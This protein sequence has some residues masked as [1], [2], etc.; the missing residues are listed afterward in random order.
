MARK[1]FV[2]FNQRCE[3]RDSYI[4]EELRPNR[5]YDM[6]N[7]EGGCGKLESSVYTSRS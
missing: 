6:K 4:G 2:L 5:D 7:I 3:G 1:Y